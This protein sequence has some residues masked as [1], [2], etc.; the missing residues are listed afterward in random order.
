MTESKLYV[1]IIDDDAS[2]RK[3]LGRLVSVFSYRVQTFGLARE[4]LDSLRP[5]CQP[6]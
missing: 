3:A 5:K 2:V 4:F 6:A 1:A